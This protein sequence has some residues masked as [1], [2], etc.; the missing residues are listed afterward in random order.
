M[1]SSGI[2]LGIDIGTSAA[3][4]GLFSETG[5]LLA[6]ASRAYPTAMPRPGCFEQSPESWWE[7]VSH[8]V[9]EVTRDHLGQKIAAVGMTSQICAP[10]FVRRD[11][12]PLRPT[13]V[14]W[15]TRAHDCVAELYKRIPRETLDKEL[16]IDLPPSPTWPLPRL[17]WLNRHEN[18]TLS[19][20]HALL[21]PKDYVTFKL[22]GEFAT[23]VS[24]SRGLVNLGTGRVATDVLRSLGVRTDLLPRLV[25]PYGI[26][27][28][29]SATAAAET[30]I[31]A[32]VPVMAGFNDFNASALGTGLRDGD[33]FDISGTS[34][35]IGTV[36]PS[37]T[38]NCP[39]L[40][41]AP[42]IPGLYLLYGVTSCGGGSWDWFRRAHGLRWEDLA[43]DV[44]QVS[45]NSEP[46]LFLPYLLGE[47]APVWDPR[48]SGAFVGLRTSHTRGHMARAVLE[49]VAFSVKQ[50]LDLV[51]TTAGRPGT[52]LHVSG[53]AARLALWNQIKA[54]VLDRPIVVNEAN[55]VAARGAAI[56]AAIG[57]GVYPDYASAIESM[58][59]AAEPVLPD[60]QLSSRYSRLFCIYK[61]LY[62]VMKDTLH[63]LNEMVVEFPKPATR[64]HSRPMAVIFSAGK[65]ARGFIAH[66]LSL[67]GYDLV[68]IE[69]SKSLVSLLRE[70]MSYPIEVMGA[71]EK[72]AV[73][74][75]FDVLDSED[76][77]SIASVIA[78]AAV[79]F[80]SIGGVNLPQIAP[81]LA[82]S[83]QR[84]REENS[85]KKLN[86]ILCENY[87][88]P[89][90]WLRSM[91]AERL[92]G[93]DREW[94][95]SQVGIAEALVLRSCIEPTE[96]MRQKDPLS[97]KVQN[98][99]QMPVD[100]DA[101]RGTPPEIS[102]LEL[103]ENFQGRLTQKL[104]TYNAINA[105][106]CYLGHLRGYSILS[107]AAN[108]PEISQLAAQAGREASEALIRRFVFEPE[109]Q[110][111]FADAALAK[112]QKKEIVDPIERNARDPIRKLG[113][114]DRL[115]GPACLSLE[116][117]GR[118]VVLAQSIA[119]ALHYQCA[120]DPAAV[121]LQEMIR[122]EGI[123]AVLRQV[124]G[125][126][127]DSEL[128]RMILEHYASQ[129]PSGEPGPSSAP[130]K[131]SQKVEA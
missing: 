10:T 58:T 29:V 120:T 125:I 114:N 11:G 67:A 128:A 33:S 106:V 35:H 65:I 40:T 90:K 59:G 49:G 102:G 4:I 3:K 57:S 83:F 37:P 16:G 7:A 31:E 87:Y 75:G 50:V 85:E 45:A 129:A 71:P 115:V 131:N 118:P 17:L 122:T 84:L 105:V 69:K 126:A 124:C 92:P 97:L 112:Y 41:C 119:A 42:Y 89:A 30:G 26:V 39:Q 38:R 25:E 48:T 91:I 14:Y 110:R 107:D 43:A 56:L 52:A 98:A 77:E 79:V 62:P 72:S 96:E 113:R 24:S 70:R 127:P 27:G 111:K 46:L 6:M 64:N 5:A 21:Q 55:L 78:G 81:T 73:I 95:N 74:S 116:T 99:W 100:C 1:S 51:E 88:Q 13:M 66:L 60:A 2:L 130:Q 80:V 103:Q 123:Q 18:D 32:G 104:F 15:D 68:F 94:F 117:G 93:P 54:S 44:A 61:E 8:G 36:I 47:R 101:L 34:D 53:G 20:A 109:D 82:A 86:V 19:Q 23:D 12:S 22:T 63:K 76:V 9:R 108:D 121:R 28:R